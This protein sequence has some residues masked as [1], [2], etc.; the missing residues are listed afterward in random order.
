M[1]QPAFEII[2]SILE[3]WK[4]AIQSIMF[5]VL[6]AAVFGGKKGKK[7]SIMGVLFI[8]A[9]LGLGMLPFAVWVRYG[10]SAFG[11]MGYVWIYYK[12]QIGK[13]FFVILAF[14][15]LHCL[16]LQQATH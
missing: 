16:S 5:L 1:S 11:I 15:N 7:D 9:N 8:F 2:N 12:K 14:Y 13:A 4:I 6:W 3:I 10:V